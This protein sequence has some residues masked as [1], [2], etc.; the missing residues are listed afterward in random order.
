MDSS[1]PVDPSKLLTL[2][3]AANVLAVSIDVLLRW[4]E[5]QILKPTIT[6]AGQIGYT[7]A[8]IDQFMRIQQSLRAARPQT[9]K[10]ATS[11]TEPFSRF[12]SQ[13]SNYPDQQLTSPH[14]TI[15]SSQNGNKLS[16][17]RFFSSVAAITAVLVVAVLAQQGQFNTLIDQYEKA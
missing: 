9:E 3:E 17:M 6:Q 16:S 1:R 15:S 11:P 14:K 7:Q 8:Q 4:N 12:A 10:I 2:Q 5:H 13:V